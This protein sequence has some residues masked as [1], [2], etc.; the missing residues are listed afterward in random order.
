MEIETVDI[1]SDTVDEVAVETTNT[2]ETT[3]ISETSNAVDAVGILEVYGLVC[4]FMAAD[5]GCKAG[6]VRLED[7]DRNKPANAEDL[8]VPLIIAV[9]FRGSVSD[10]E[11][12]MEAAAEVAKNCTDVISRHVI[13]SPIG[14]EMLK[15]SGFDV[16]PDSCSCVNDSGMHDSD[17]CSGVSDSESHGFIVES[18]GFVEVSGIVR[19]TTALDTMCKTADVKFVTQQ[20]KLGGRLVTTIIKGEASAVTAA[21]DAV[22]SDNYINPAVVGAILNPHPEIMRI[23]GRK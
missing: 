20:K 1:T 2:T 7:F 17:I 5:A 16:R 4:A 23:I 12:S 18:H 21:L 15:L 6:N 8:P 3:G 11:A 13:S 10:V 22:K 9:K 14:E 19:A